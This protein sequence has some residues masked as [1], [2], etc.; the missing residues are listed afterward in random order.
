MAMPE[1]LEEVLKNRLDN[2]VVKYKE[3]GKKLE[4]RQMELIKEVEP[5]F[6]GSVREF[7][8]KHT[9]ASDST[10][11]FAKHY[12]IALKKWVKFD[13]VDGD[14]GKVYDEIGKTVLS[15]SK[16][17]KE[18]LIFEYYSKIMETLIGILFPPNDIEKRYDDSMDTVSYTGEYPTTDMHYDDNTFVVEEMPQETPP[19]GPKF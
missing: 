16:R 1:K 2:I 12:D 19:S 10:Y 8:D 7:F 14:I 5:S 11:Y 13:L 4:R 6:E 3:A 9:V 15:R 17:T 18:H